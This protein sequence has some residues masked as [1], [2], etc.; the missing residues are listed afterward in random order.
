MFT[1]S[2]PSIGKIR[3]Y[4]ISYHVIAIGVD[5][6]RRGCDC[7]L[8]KRYLHACD[9]FLLEKKNQIVEYRA[10]R[11]CVLLENIRPN[12]LNG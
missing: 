12:Q 5:T 11:V 8:F 6:E 2:T 9:V 1:V 3:F 4:F 7:N 10:N